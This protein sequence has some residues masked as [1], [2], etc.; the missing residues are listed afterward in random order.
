MLA[1]KLTIDH[2]FHKLRLHDLCVIIN[3][4]VDKI[5]GARRK[6]FY[7]SIKN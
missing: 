4:G 5:C 3:N 2:A 1:R 7:S 6:E